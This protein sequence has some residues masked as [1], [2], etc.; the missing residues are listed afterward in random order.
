MDILT[1]CWWQ[2]NQTPGVSD[3]LDSLMLIHTNDTDGV[4]MLLFMLTNALNYFS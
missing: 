2:I 4:L 1:Q 3:L